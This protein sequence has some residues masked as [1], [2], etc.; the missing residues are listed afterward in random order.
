MFQRS[1]QQE[2]DRLTSKMKSY[3]MGSELYNEAIINLDEFIESSNDRR[4]FGMTAMGGIAVVRDEGEPNTS[5]NV[6]IGGL[7]LISCEKS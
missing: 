4:T 1:R 3:K 5:R 7:R 2:Y 6:G